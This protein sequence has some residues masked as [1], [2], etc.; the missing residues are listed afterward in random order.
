ML[1]LYSLIQSKSVE[2]YNISNKEKILRYIKWGKNIFKYFLC[3]INK[4][5]DN[6]DQNLSAN[7][8]F[9]NYPSKI[10]NI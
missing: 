4:T 1:N 5:I 6:N 2:K 3:L 8:L 9:M 7:I 10:S